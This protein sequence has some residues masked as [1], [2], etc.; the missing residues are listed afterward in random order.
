M[1]LKGPAARIFALLLIFSLCANFLSAGLSPVK[2]YA[3]S[4]DVVISQVYGGGG[5]SGAPYK[6]DFVELFNRGAVPVSLTGWSVQYASATGSGYFSNNPVVAIS[7]TLLPGQYYLIKLA[8][9]ANGVDLPAE[10]ATGLIY[11]SSSGGKVALVMSTSG[12]ACNSYS[13]ATPT[14]LSLIKDLVGWGS[15][16]FFEGSGAAPGTSNSTAVSRDDG[17]YIETDNNTN[18]FSLG[19]PA[20]RNTSSPFYYGSGSTGP[21]GVGAAI[22]GS[23]LAGDSTLLTVAVTPGTNPA[24]TGLVV[25]GDLSLIGGS[26]TQVFVD[27]GTNGDI[28][29]GD[30]IFSWTETIEPGTTAGLKSLGCSIV[31][32]QFRFGVVSIELNVVEIIPIGTVQ[33]PAG[34]TDDGSTQRSPYAPSSGNGSGQTVCVQGVIYEKTLQAISNSVNTY[35]GFFI[36]N[37]AATAD[38]DPNTSDGILVFMNYDTAI[39][40]PSGPYTPIAGDEIV[41][42]GVVSEYYNMTELNS[43]VLVEPVVR[44]GVDLEAELP[45]VVVNPPVDLSDANRYW[46]RLEGMRVQVPVGSIVLGGRNVFSPA[47]AEI[48]LARPDSTIALRTDPYSRKAFRDSHPVDDNFDPVNWDGNGYRILIGS[49]GIKATT[50]DAQALLDPARSYSTLADSSIGGLNFTFSKYRIEITEQPIFTEGVDPA[51][52]NP[53]RDSG[54]REYSIA[55]YNLENLYD[56]RDNPFSGC[57]YPTDSGQPMVYP[58]LSGITPPFDYVPANDAFYQARLNDIALQIINDLHSP[59]VL[60]LQEVENQDIGIVIGGNLVFGAIDNAD[61]KPDVLQELALKIAALGGPLY[62]SA[63]DR[64]SSDLRGITPAF[65]YRT[66]RVELLP[67]AGDP[68]LGSLPVINYPGAAVPY[69]LDISNPKS[70]NAVTAVGVSVCDTHWVFPRAPAIGLFRIYSN[71]IGSGGYRDVYVI[72]NHF[73]SGPTMCVAHRIEEAKYNAAIVAYLQ[74]ADPEASIVLGGDLN[75]YPRPDDPFAPIGQPTSSDQLGPLYDPDLGLTNLWD[76]LLEESPESAYSY[77]YLG[78]AQTLDQIFVNRIMLKELGEF[79]VAHINS[80]FPADYAGDVARGTSD[81]DPNAAIFGIVNTISSGVG[82]EVQ[83]V[84]N[85]ISLVF[86]AL[87]VLIIIV[88]GLAF[89]LIRRRLR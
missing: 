1:K 62:D 4:T 80:D 86:L 54:N 9:G 28:T 37:T 19:V 56:Y 87:A 88:L 69:N 76:V 59:D 14:Q 21:A 83:P 84:K 25:T 61:G 64:D 52:N 7:G 45:P 10:N 63:F 74:A 81:H 68:L 11:M 35:K 17:G 15:A 42:A 89:G 34:D 6:N 50:G 29:P 13:N 41:L 55:D 16:N 60:M 48:W 72:N 31:D 23:R 18:D 47:D 65:L 22:P 26:N 44:S 77:I 70:L 24:S 46:E 39:N 49:L 85:Q 3:L 78:M 40:G 2:V 43:P 27:N 66:D 20:P 82:G 32:A 67:A 75:V 58:Y 79:S 38:A 57:D 30:N 71:S 51:E 5:G 53:P 33:G 8:G 12:L 36:Q 73:K